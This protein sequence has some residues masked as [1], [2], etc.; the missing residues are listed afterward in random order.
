MR[1]LA[2]SDWRVQ[3]I[4]DVFTFLENCGDPVDLILYGG[5]DVRRFEEEGVNHFTRLSEYA[6]GRAVLGVLGNDDDSAQ[7]R[8]VLRGRN[9]H[10]LHRKPYVFGEFAFIGLEASTRGPAIIQH[11]EAEV[12]KQLQ[13]QHS[14][15]RGKRLIVLS[16]APPY[17]I[18]DR[19]IRFASSHEKTHHIGSTALVHFIKR[20]PVDLV[21]CGH[22]H[23]HGGRALKHGST[24]IVNV[25][26]HDSPGANGNFAL[27]DLDSAGKEHHRKGV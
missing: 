19:G 18:L 16:H 24:T 5:D 7:A 20:T 21:V 26:S 10:D 27:I 25:A 6:N 4:S 14:Q 3:D 9:V 22:C 11:T 13:K 8:R 17:G 2:F 1:L 23:S 15:V 12:R